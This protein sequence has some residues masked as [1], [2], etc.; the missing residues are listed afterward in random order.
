MG[1]VRG[2]EKGSRKLNGWMGRKAFGTKRFSGVK[3][4]YCG[5]KGGKRKGGLECRRVIWVV[6]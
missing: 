2:G 4:G 5:D 6:K 3:G 1:Q